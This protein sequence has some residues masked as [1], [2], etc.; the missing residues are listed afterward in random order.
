MALLKSGTTVYGTANIQSVLYVGQ[1][2]PNTS[3]STTTGS[4]VVSGGTGISGNLYTGNIVVSGSN[5]TITMGGSGVTNA[6]VNIG[7]GPQVTSTANLLVSACTSATIIVQGTSARQVLNSTTGDA[8]LN[9]ASTVAGGLASL[10]I[11]GS[12]TNLFVG[13]TAANTV[14]SNNTLTLASNQTGGV[15][16]IITQ[17][18][19]ASLVQYYNGL[20]TGS[21][22]SILLTQTGYGQF[23]ACSAYIYANTNESGINLSSYGTT[24]EA[25][26]KS[27]LNLTQILLNNSNGPALL[28]IRTG[29][30]CTATFLLS[31]TTGPAYANV[32]ATGTA[33]QVNIISN[34]PSTSTAAGALVVTG[35]VGVAGNIYSGGVINTTTSSV[36]NFLELQ[37]GSTVRYAFSRDTGSG[38]IVYINSGVF[39]IDINH[40]FGTGQYIDF[41]HQSLSALRVYNSSG[42]HV[43]YLSVYPALTNISPSLAATGSDANIGITLQPKGSGFVN[44]SSNL[45]ISGAITGNVAPPTSATSNVAI[46]YLSIPQNLNPLAANTYTLALTD[47]GKHIYLTLTSA[48]ANSAN[49]YIPTTANVAFPTGAAVNIVLNGAYSANVIANSGV[50]MYLAG[51]TGGIT[52][53]NTRILAPYSMASVLCVAAN[54]W[55]IS[56]VGIT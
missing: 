30:A 48:N 13:N 49:I 34:L 3:T 54:T 15:S 43:N 19:T 17:A 31:G 14:V 25:S 9:I 41:R 27:N 44:V 4:L 8:S 32:G 5:P 42:S 39:A 56:G 46:G 22:S 52:A 20:A 40:N 2:T 29:A 51:N 18:N 26:I 23:G 47:Q 7:D 50:T 24:A 28:N 6:T 36:A 35:G 33:S 12:V 38:S 10:T 37:D 16:K 11:N 45:I 55:Y 1:I 21:N 53:S